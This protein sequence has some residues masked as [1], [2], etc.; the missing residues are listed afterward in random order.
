V[1]WPWHLAHLAHH[2]N[3][4][5]LLLLDNCP[6]HVDLDKN[7]LP[8]KLVLLFFPPNCTSFLQPADMGMIACLKLG[9]KANMLRRLLA[10]CDDDS[11]YKEALVQENE[12]EEAVRDWST[13]AKHTYLMRWRS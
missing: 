10:I 5:F 12:Q 7:K 2:G 13:A 8:A 11:L 3:V 9:Y 1:L 4:C 6:A